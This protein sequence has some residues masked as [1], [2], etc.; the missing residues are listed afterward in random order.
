MSIAYSP[1][2]RQ[3]V[4]EW[5]KELDDI[6]TNLSA[7]H[8]LDSP[9]WVYPRDRAAEL[10]RDLDRMDLATGSTVSRLYRR[11]RRDWERAATKHRERSACIR[12]REQDALEYPAGHGGQLCRE[13]EDLQDHEYVK[14]EAEQRAKAATAVAEGRPR[15]INQRRGF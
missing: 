10:V 12:C 9:N 13:C 2:T 11:V 7:S 4:I 5:I 14:W 15:A 3:K 1:E 6:A 8:G